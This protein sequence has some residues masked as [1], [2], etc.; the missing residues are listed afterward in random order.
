MSLLTCASQAGLVR[1]D[2]FLS[3]NGD[4]VRFKPYA[5]ILDILKRETHVELVVHA[6]AVTDGGTE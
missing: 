1:G 2:V 3:I 4:D 5:A 6:G